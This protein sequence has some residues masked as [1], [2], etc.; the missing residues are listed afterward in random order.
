MKI[1]TILKEDEV[2]ITLTVSE[3][4]WLQVLLDNVIRNTLAD[5]SLSGWKPEA[6]RLLEILRQVKKEGERI[7][8]TSP[9]FEQSELK[10]KDA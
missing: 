5:P 2:Y 10:F 3:L 4:V 7:I 9:E 6:S 8:Q 1:K